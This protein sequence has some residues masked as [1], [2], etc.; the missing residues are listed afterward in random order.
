M[1]QC[2]KGEP[3]C[4]PL[5]LSLILRVLFKTL[6]MTHAQAARQT[7]AKRNLMAGKTAPLVGEAAGSHILMQPYVRFALRRLDGNEGKHLHHANSARNTLNGGKLRPNSL[8][9]KYQNLNI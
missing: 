6:A 5:N 3:T 2:G 7:A 1:S 8:F 4:P 9:F